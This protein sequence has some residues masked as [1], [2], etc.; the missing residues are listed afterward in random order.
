MGKDNIFKFK[1][2]SIVQNSSA[3]KVGTDG[4]LLGAWTDVES[5]ENVLDIGSG[6]GVISLMIAQRSNAIITAVEIEE[7][8]SSE[9]EMNFANSKWSNRLNI[10]NQSVIDFAATHNSQFDHIVCNPPFFNNGVRSSKVQRSIARHN[11]MLPF[12][13]LIASVANLLTTNGKFDVVIPFDIEQEFIELCSSN[14]LYI[15]K[16]TMVKPNYTRPVK[17]ILIS[18]VNSTVSQIEETEIQIEK[19]ERHNYTDEYKNLTKD[20]YLAF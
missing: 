16:R 11:D 4:V 9:S 6:T 14:K 10:V 1:H 18:F 8:A 15:R 12:D 5:A 19:E 2:F 3:M 7:A 20:F 17:R 13:Q